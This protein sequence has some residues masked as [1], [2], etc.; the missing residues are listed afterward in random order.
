MP[1]V[2][3]GDFTFMVGDPGGNDE[4]FSYQVGLT[5]TAGAA[6]TG[7]STGR[8]SPQLLRQYRAASR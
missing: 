2:A 5:S 6:A 1:G 3:A 8:A 4:S 7:A